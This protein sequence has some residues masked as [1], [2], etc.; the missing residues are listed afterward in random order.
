MTPSKCKGRRIL[1]HLAFLLLTT[2]SYSQRTGD[3]WTNATTTSFVSSA[4]S[5]SASA[6][7]PSVISSIEH[8]SS[9]NIEGKSSNVG[10]FIAAGMGMTHSADTAIGESPL[11]IVPSN[12]IKL[13]ETTFVSASSSAPMITTPPTTGN[14]TISFAGDCWEQW[15][16]YWFASSSVSNVFTSV[17]MLTTSTSTDTI[18]SI[19]VTTEH[20]SGTTTVTVK[21]GAFA[22][23]TYTT[24][25]QTSIEVV[26]LTS[27]PLNTILRTKTWSASYLSRLSENV[28][29][30]RP[31]CVLPMQVP[32]CQSSWETWASQ[33]FEAM[34]T[35]PT[36]CADYTYFIAASLQPPSCQTAFSSFSHTSS[37]IYENRWRHP[38]YCT[39]AAVTGALCSSF[40]D[41]VVSSAKEVGQITD[42]VVAAGYYSIEYTTIE[43]SNNHLV[44]STSYVPFWNKSSSLAPGCTL[45]CHSCQINGGTVQLIYWP[46]ASSTW[47]NGYYHAVSGNS[48]ET[49][50]AVTLGTT[51]TSPTVYVSFDSL[52]ARDSCSMFDKTYS[53]KILAITETA[54][55]SSIWGFGKWNGLGATASF[56]FTDL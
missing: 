12:T 21:N 45:G 20:F 24:I 44:T 51:L 11:S 15:S 33:K 48:N 5:T 4:A 29:V 18:W 8:L 39:Q 25:T 31:T 16:S 19:S 55:L 53:N 10:D 14:V 1:L 22:Q 13:E 35:Y 49:L 6:L 52:Y 3:V 46:P 34:P 36:E 26:T 9:H 30:L 27:S 7:E 17:S 42:G 2:A 23:K 32:E 41:S 43:S 38:P 47:V 40:A 56:N 37:I 50:T 28:T 54:N